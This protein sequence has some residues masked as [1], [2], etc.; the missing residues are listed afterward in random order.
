MRLWSL[1]ALCP[2]FILCVTACRP[3]WQDAIEK[4]QALRAAGDDVNA[5]AAFR[6]ACDQGA[7]PETKACEAARST[8]ARAAHEAIERGESAC[9]AGELGVCFSALHGARGVTAENTKE[10]AT[11]EE[12]LEVASS[13]HMESC[14]RL[15]LQNLDGAT[16]AYRCLSLLRK[17]VALPAHATRIDRQAQK[18]AAFLLEEAHRHEVEQAFGAGAVHAGLARCMVGG[19]ETKRLFD[20]DG[21]R[22]LDQA[23]LPAVVTIS[24]LSPAAKDRLCAALKPGPLKCSPAAPDLVSSEKGA[25]KNGVL[26]NGALKLATL[27]HSSKPSTKVIEY[28]A[29]IDKV[30]NPDFD[31]LTREIEVD[32]RALRGTEKDAANGKEA[33]AAAEAALVKAAN[34]T[35]CKEATERERICTKADALADD[36]KKANDDFDTKKVLLSRTPRTVEQNRMATHSWIETQHRW[37][38]P[39]EV[40]V[41]GAAA[42]K[43]VLV[44]E[45]FEAPGFPPAGIIAKKLNEPTVA[46]MRPTIEERATAHAQAELTRQLVARGKALAPTCH[47][48]ADDGDGIDCQL[49]ALWYGGADPVPTW[50]ND[51]A[52]RVEAPWPRALCIE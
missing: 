52:A 41:D 39:F 24:G 37:E 49:R 44:V 14:S 40:T 25:E 15:P 32:R 36:A 34:C 38:L 3:V 22:F 4:E 29:G 18:I 28:I 7:P 42:L 10:R 48:I 30:P 12:L 26:A 45:D 2:C 46:T 1:L 5:A 33:C 19:S 43:D 13:M 20:D 51:L 17:E 6:Q 16:A 31:R 11:I 27:K 9:R 35:A 21:A 50:L 8:A 23:R 47:A